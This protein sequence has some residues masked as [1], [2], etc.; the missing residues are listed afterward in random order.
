[1]QML[2]PSA[3]ACL[4]GAAALLGCGPAS[5][6]NADAGKLKAAIIYNIIRFVDFT[7][8]VSAPLSLCLAR[9]AAVPR[10]LAAL[11]GQRAGNRAIV[12]IGLDAAKAGSCNVIYLGNSVADIPKV[13]QRGVLVIADGPGVLPAGGTIGLVQTGAQIR[14]EV[15]VGTARQDKVVISSKLLRLAARVQQ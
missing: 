1:M 13:R 12:L 11:N 10:E 7:P 15:N 2:L 3:R 14:F 5:A 8:S 6:Q 9:N 4:I